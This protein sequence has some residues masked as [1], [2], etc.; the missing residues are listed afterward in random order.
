MMP[1][2][3]VSLVTFNSAGVIAA[4]LRSIPMDVPVYVVDNGSNDNTLDMI[5]QERP[6]AVI[7][8]PHR[9]MGFGRAHNLNARKITAD[10]ILVLN[11]DTV[12]QSACLVYL[13]DAAQAP[14]AG[15]VG[16][17]HQND[18]GDVQSCFHNDLDY[19]PQLAPYKRKYCRKA[20]A[21]TIVPD[22][23][24]CVE[25]ITGA[26]ML[27][28]RDVYALV[29]GFNPKLFM[30]FED[31]DICARIRKAGYNIILA[32]QA[33]VIHYEGK[34]SGSSDRVQCIKGY[35][36]ERSRKIVHAAYHGRGV[37]YYG[38]IGTGLLRCLRRAVKYRLKGKRSRA[39]YYMAGCKGLLS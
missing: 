17:L 38:L 8:V 9:N 10:Y 15:M 18:E 25:Q 2:L 23:P 28:R 36:F 7:T 24:V 3:A 39:V 31:D 37:S 12:L 29:K 20:V 32:P 16:A 5:R 27:I 14:D 34:S 30:Y 11:P 33:R 19:Y 26:L 35:H 21:A 4:C 22:G 6:D 1:S 13:L